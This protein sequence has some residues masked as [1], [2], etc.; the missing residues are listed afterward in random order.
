MLSSRHILAISLSTDLL[1]NVTNNKSMGRIN[2]VRF[3]KD[4]P[5]LFITSCNTGC[6][7]KHFYIVVTAVNSGECQ[8]CE[9][10]KTGEGTIGCVGIFQSKINVVGLTY[11]KSDVITLYLSFTEVFFQ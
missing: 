7:I 6:R 10:A 1:V 11:R 5:V 8:N 2:T 9:A 3:G 4:I